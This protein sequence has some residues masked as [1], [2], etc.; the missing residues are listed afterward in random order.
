MVNSMIRNV[1]TTYNYAL[2]SSN[3]FATE[4][5][6]QLHAIRKCYFI[7]AASGQGMHNILSAPSVPL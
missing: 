6:K 1:Y 3:S 7:V 4:S 2:A 5:C